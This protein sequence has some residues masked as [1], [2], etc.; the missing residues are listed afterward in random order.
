MFRYI[1]TSNINPTNGVWHS[2]TF[3]NGHGMCDTVTR[4]KHNT[5]RAAGRVQTK[6][7]LNTHVHGRHIECLEKNLGCCFTVRTRVQRRLSKQHRMLLGQRL[8]L[9]IIYMIPNQF[10]VLPVFND[11]MLHRIL[12]PQQSA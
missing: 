3:V 8:E 2:E 12:H 5:G 7:R 11:A 10:H 1:T 6:D 9:V 4:I